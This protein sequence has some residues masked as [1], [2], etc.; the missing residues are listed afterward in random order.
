MG[1]GAAHERAADA[2]ASICIPDLTVE[3]RFWNTL[4]TALRAVPV[5]TRSALLWG[6][7]TGTLFRA[8]HIA[9]FA[10]LWFTLALACL[11]VE[12]HLGWADM[13]SALAAA[14]VLI[15]VLAGNTFLHIA[16]AFSC[17]FFKQE[18][19]TTMFLFISAGTIS[20]IPDLGFA[21]SVRFAL[22]WHALASALFLVPHLGNGV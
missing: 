8:K 12:V 17:G 14:R 6:A 1:G 21:L 13:R 5:I 22:L 10:S 19:F 4:A 15:E 11:R 3:T 18:I 20:G 7:D 9:L 16:N 2:S